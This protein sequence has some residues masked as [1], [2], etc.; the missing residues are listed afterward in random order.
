MTSTT[1]QTQ[2][3]YA[4]WEAIVDEKTAE[5][6]IAELQEISL[7]SK[8]SV[9]AHSSQDSYTESFSG[10]QPEELKKSHKTTLQGYRG[11]GDAV[12]RMIVGDDRKI[13]HDQFSTNV[14]WQFDRFEAAQNRSHQSPLNFVMHSITQLIRPSNF[15]PQWILSWGIRN[16]HKNGSGRNVMVMNDVGGFA[17]T[18]KGPARTRKLDV[19]GH[20]NLHFSHE[21]YRPNPQ[22]RQQVDCHMNFGWKEDLSDGD[23][24]ILVIRNPRIDFVGEGPLVVVLERVDLPVEYAESFPVLNDLESWLIHGPDRIRRQMSQSRD[25]AAK[26]KIPLRADPKWTKTLSDGRAVSLLMVGNPQEHPHIWWTPDGNGTSPELAELMQDSGGGLAP[27]QCILRITPATEFSLQSE[28]ISFSNKPNIT[29]QVATSGPIS[30]MIRY[31]A[32]TTPPDVDQ[33]ESFVRI[34][35]EHPLNETGGSFVLLVG[36]GDWK[37]IGEIVKGTP[38]KVG[39]RSVHVIGIHDFRHG[40]TQQM[41]VHSQFDASAEEELKL[42]A[43]R[44]DGKVIEPEINA[45]IGLNVLMSHAG[46]ESEGFS[47]QFMGISEKDVDHFDVLVRPLEK[48][49]FENVNFTPEGLPALD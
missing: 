44:K 35:L 16:R 25:W 30:R 15:S 26:A 39:G 28:I 36:C 33:T 29:T 8:S 40:F 24:V 1:H 32:G 38:S 41:N 17:S 49:R 45:Q 3:Y 4:T 6:L 12:R 46:N 11:A 37:K 5:K 13:D 43:V 22:L 27:S 34:S 47:E 21:D 42:I 20:Y 2:P 7:T 18:K 14:Q 19:N 10:D 48:V 31:P 9:G 23:A